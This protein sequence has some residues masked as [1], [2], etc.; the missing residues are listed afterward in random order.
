MKRVLVI[1]ATGYLGRHVVSELKRQGHWV[2]ALSRH[3]DSFSNNPFAPDEVFTGEITQ[4]ETLHGLMDDVDYVFSSLGITRQRDKLGFWDVDYQG[5]KTVLEMAMA[6]RI[7]K[8]VMISVVRPELAQHLDIVGAREAF[9]DKLRA[10]GLEYTIVR[11]T[12]FFSDMM[13]FLTMAKSGRVFLFGSGQHRMNPID[14]GDLARVCVDAFDRQENEI[15]VGGP[16]VL[17]YNEIAELAFS[18]LNLKPNI[19]H[20]PNWV[21]SAAIALLYPFNRKTYTIIKFFA[22]LTQHDIVAP[23]VQGKH[24][25]E[26]YQTAG[27][28]L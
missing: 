20:L 21:T 3:T 24:L 10:S 2:R 7:K 17:S 1:G 11:A 13:E 4:P 16:D 12:G 27:R 9:V 8:F 5:N 14:G 19:I 28:T 22:T 25:I 23:P 18:A 26:A 6:A 15:E